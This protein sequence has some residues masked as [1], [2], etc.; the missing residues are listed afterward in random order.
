MDIAK[1]QGLPGLAGRI[2]QYTGKTPPSY[3]QVWVS[4]V[5]GQQPQIKLINGRYYYDDDDVPAIAAA[6]GIDPPAPRRPPL[7]KAAA[8]VA[9]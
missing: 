4:I 5:N 7:R 3:R 6:L 9:A 2:G 1:R 8:K